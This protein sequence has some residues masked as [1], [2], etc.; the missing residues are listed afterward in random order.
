MKKLI[1]LLLMFVPALACAEVI[2]AAE[3]TRFSLYYDTQESQIILEDKATGE[4][5]RS[6]PDNYEEDDQAAGVNKINRQSDLIVQYYN[7]TYVTSQVN[8]YSGSIK[9]GNFTWELIENGVEIRYYFPKQGFVIP[10][11][12]VLEEDC[13]AASILSDEIEEGVWEDEDTNDSKTQTVM[14]IALLPFMGAADGDDDGYLVIPDGSGALI[15]F[16]NGR[17]TASLYQREVYGRDD[18]LTLKKSATNTCDVNMPIF[19]M[20][21]NGRAL[22][23][24]AENGEYQAQLSAAVNGQLTGYS[25]AYF[26]VQY[27]HMESNTIM[28][29]TASSKDVTLATNVFRDMGR[30]TVRYYPL[31]A[32]QATYVDIA[33]AYREVLGLDEKRLA[34]D[35]AVTQLAVI[36]SIPSVDTVL[37]IPYESIRVLTDYDDL[38]QMIENFTEAGVEKLNVRYAGWSDQSVRGK[39]VS[40]LDLD[41]RLGGS[42]SFKNLRQIAQ[43]YGTTLTLEMDLLNLYKNGNGYWSLF[44]G[45]RSVNSTA[46]Q[47]SPFLQSTGYEDPEGERWYLLSP[48]R[49]PKLAQKIVNGM[50]NEVE[51]ITLGALGNTVYSSFGKKGISRTKTGLL[52]QETLGTMADGFDW[53]TAHCASAYAFAYLDQVDEAPCASSRYDVM[54]EDI[55]LYQLVTHGSMVLYTEP[56]N[57]QGNVQRTLLKAIEYGMYPS[58]QVIAG[59]T[60]L[61]AGT[62]YASWFATSLADWREEIIAAYEQMEPLGMYAGMQMTGHQKVSDTLSVTM[63]ENGDMVIVNYGDEAVWYN[64]VEISAQGYAIK[65]AER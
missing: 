45:T 39:M 1:L 5:W 44:A 16:G 12:Y 33:A 23:A 8:S 21:R 62:D 60:A 32:E 17:T 40:A 41:S 29:S 51:G 56:V 26:T 35:P 46:K 14:S 4:S 28:G 27:S 31:K 57:E 34:Q 38:A 18:T 37:G 9:K 30:F 58:W 50:A 52:W 61:L 53:L 42:K 49:A 6:T 55:P 59:D 25:N 19:G 13:L 24:V 3:N 36:A 65:E 43:K 7:A 11:Q 2:T 64:G 48:D 10:V 15:R 54:D 20:V 22:L 63:Y 47:L